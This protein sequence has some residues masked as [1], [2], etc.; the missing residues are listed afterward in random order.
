MYIVGNRYMDENVVFDGG[1]VCR[2]MLETHRGHVAHRR[3]RAPPEA[4]PVAPPDGRCHFNM[5][6]QRH[7]IDSIRKHIGSRTSAIL[8]GSAT[9]G[10]ITMVPSGPRTRTFMSFTRRRA[11]CLVFFKVVC[12]VGDQACMDVCG[13]D[14][15]N[16]PH[17]KLEELEAH[18]V[19]VLD[20]P[21][22]DALEPVV[23][24]CISV[25]GCAFDGLVGSSGCTCNQPPTT[26]QEK[27]LKGSMRRN[28]MGIMS[29]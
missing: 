26:H 27:S 18:C 23:N 6:Q 15:D 13:I 2:S 21:D 1:K 16:A 19:A 17:E 12:R 22:D 11:W 8:G 25:C 29:R 24:V 20:R 7:L 4:A 9:S 5:I 28:L 3:P 14:R 10:R